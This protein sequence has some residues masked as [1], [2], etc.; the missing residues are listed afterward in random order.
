MPTSSI[1]K[2]SFDDQYHFLPHTWATRVPRHRFAQYSARINSSEHIT[3]QNTVPTS[4]LQHTRYQY[5]AVSQLEPVQRH[6]DTDH[7]RRSSYI[8]HWRIKRWP[9]IYL[10]SYR[11]TH[12]PGY[13]IGLRRLTV[14]PPSSTWHL[15]CSPLHSIVPISWYFAEVFPFMF[16]LIIVLQVSCVHLC[17]WTSLSSRS[18]VSCRLLA[19]R[20]V[21]CVGRACTRC[22]RSRPRLAWWLD[23]D[24]ARSGDSST[25]DPPVAPCQLELRQKNRTIL[26]LSWFRL[27]QS[28]RSP[29]IWFFIFSC[30]TFCSCST[31]VRR[32][33][34]HSSDAVPIQHTAAAE[35]AA[36]V[37]CMLPW[38]RI[39]TWPPYAT[40]KPLP[41]KCFVGRY[42]DMCIVPAA[43]AIYGYLVLT[44]TRCLPSSSTQPWTGEGRFWTAGLI[45]SDRTAEMSWRLSKLCARRK[46]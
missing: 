28:K 36:E 16:A 21:R 44:T 19:S 23:D 26:L 39:C 30:S 3:R 31:Y 8:Q 4:S 1:L 13:V 35:V 46:M 18:Y 42:T 15:L 38:A 7:A 10:I 40:P 12:T 9:H 41:R 43:K 27:S 45:P 34:R 32:D 11:T 25:C 33:A 29:S 24:L 14:M 20:N 37:R 22:G 6:N 5:T 2:Q 17:R